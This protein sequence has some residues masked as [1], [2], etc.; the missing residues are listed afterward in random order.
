MTTAPSSP[1]DARRDRAG[2][3]H[4]RGEVRRPVGRPR[5]E[6]V[7]DFDRMLALHRQHRPLPAV[8]H[9]ADPLDLPLGG[10]SRPHAA[11]IT[12]RRAGRAGAGPAPAGLRRPSSEVG[13][14]LE[15]HRLCSYL[16]DVAQDFSAF[17]EQCPVLK[18]DTEVRESRLALCRGSP[19]PCSSQGSTCSGSRRPSRCEPGERP[20]EGRHQDRRDQVLS[21]SGSRGRPPMSCP[22]AGR[23]A[24]SSPGRSASPPSGGRGRRGGLEAPGPLRRPRVD[25]TEI[26][27][28][29]IPAAL[30]RW[31]AATRETSSR[32]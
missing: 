3:R 13:D 17:Y 31:I 22:A 20:V 27:S 14:A 19:W 23:R 15:P 21:A 28:R 8:R 24:R 26:W 32:P 18:A 7:F 29:V 5:R 6:Y 2:G 1:E 16:F 10:G 4:R 11:A 9:R 25:S 12:L 30:L